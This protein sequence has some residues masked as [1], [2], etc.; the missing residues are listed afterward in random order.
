[1]NIFSQLHQEHEEVKALLNDIA[2]LGNE[3]QRRKMVLFCELK[4]K[5]VAH[6]KAEEETFYQRLKDFSELDDKV[7]HSESEH[8][9]AEA[10]L[11]ELSSQDLTGAAWQQKFLKLKDAVEHHIQEEEGRVF[12]IAKQKID[13]QESSEIGRKMLQKEEQLLTA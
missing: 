7:R 3:D 6:E 10:L 11:E 5:L 4:E 12:P 9:E 13:D 8:H 2:A 1:M